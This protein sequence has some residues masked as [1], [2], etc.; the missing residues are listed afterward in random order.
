MNQHPT[1]R[2]RALAGGLAAA[3]LLVGG[4]GCT[5]GEEEQ[6]ETASSPLPSRSVGTQPT[7]EA[8]PVPTKVTIARVVGGKFDRKQRERLEKQ[9][10]RVLSSYFDDAFLG[11]EY[12][13]S[14]FAGALA[15][16]SPGAVRRAASDRDLLTNAGVGTSTEAV[17]A[18]TKDARLDV[19]VPKRLVAGLTARIRLVFVQERAD[20]ADQ[21][22]TVSGRLLLNR[23]KSGPW[24]IFG[25]DLTRSSVPVAKGASS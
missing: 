25:Y 20:G 5:S 6:P 17:V 11:G 13:R 15:T 9:I 23:K 16:F 4:A 24:Q 2:S 22:V 8:K 19:L 1:R 12:P 18:R 14:D 10:A 7:L 21:R 3:L